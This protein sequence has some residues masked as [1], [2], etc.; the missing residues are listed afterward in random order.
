[1]TSRGWEAGAGALTVLLGTAGGQLLGPRGCCV[2]GQLDGRVGSSWQLL[3][4]LRPTMGCFQVLSG[5]QTLVTGGR[6]EAA[7]PKWALM[8]PSWQSYGV[9]ENKSAAAG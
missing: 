4:P 6:I 8:A 7:R 5:G 2:S 9:S 3:A 1:M